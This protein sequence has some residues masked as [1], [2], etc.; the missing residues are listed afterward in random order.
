MESANCWFDHFIDILNDMQVTD[1]AGTCYLRQDG[2]AE[3]L[4][5]TC[6]RQSQGHRFFFIGNGASASMA[7]LIAA[8][9]CKNGHLRTEVF[10]DLALLTALVNDLGVEQ[11]FANP[12]R[13]QACAGDML[14][15]ISSSGNS[16]NILAAVDAARDLDLYVMTL[17]AMS[18]DNALRTRGDI[19]FYVPAPT[20]GFAESAH[21]A[22][23]HYWVDAVIEDRRPSD[24]LSHR[25]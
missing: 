15:A 3:L 4:R 9:L 11:M 5:Q 18:A 8:D 21:A 7:S 13:E 17:S 24:A 2:F 10:T 12:L 20:Y 14:V 25:T 22:V 6:V 23:L 1:L 16:A 19:N